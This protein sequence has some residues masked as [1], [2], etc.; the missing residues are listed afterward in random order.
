MSSEIEYGECPFCG[1]ET[2][3][4]RTYFYYSIKGCECHNNEHFE[5]VCHCDKCVPT[6]PK[7]IHPIFKSLDEEAYISTITNILPRRIEGQ[8]IITEKIIDKDKIYKSL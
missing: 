3:L 1:K 2:K 8:F 5:I 7:E 6:I 4:E